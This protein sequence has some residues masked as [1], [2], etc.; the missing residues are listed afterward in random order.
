MDLL[1]REKIDDLLFQTDVLDQ[2]YVA[3]PEWSWIVSSLYSTTL[4]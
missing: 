3:I 1:G 2:L 4:H